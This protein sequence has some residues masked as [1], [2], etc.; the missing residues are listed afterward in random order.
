MAQTPL[1]SARIKKTRQTL[2]ANISFF[3]IGFSP[4]ARSAQEPPHEHFARGGNDNH[5]VGGWVVRC[6]SVVLSHKR[7]AH[8]VVPRATTL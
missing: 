6:Q 8:C 5:I 3:L 7:C 1:L 2:G 4:N